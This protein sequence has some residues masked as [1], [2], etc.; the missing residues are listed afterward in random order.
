MDGVTVPVVLPFRTVA[1]PTGQIVG[2][3]DFNN[4]GK[5]DI[6]W[7]NTAT[8]ENYVWYMDG[9]NRDR[10]LLALPARPIQTGTLWALPT[11]TATAS[12]TS[13]GGTPQPVRTVSGT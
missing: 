5:P 3:A 6:L 1:D 10:A 9:V 2:T 7:R 8:G 13:S 11:S 12:P 4:D